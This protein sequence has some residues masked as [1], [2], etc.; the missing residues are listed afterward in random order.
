MQLEKQ[1]RRAELRAQAEAAKGAGKGPAAP[2]GRLGD[3]SV[4]VD[5]FPATRKGTARTK[6]N[7]NDVHSVFVRRKVAMQ[8]IMCKATASHVHS[9]FEDNSRSVLG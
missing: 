3:W 2:A 1:A 7:E 4:A 5:T 6:A 9:I 8:V